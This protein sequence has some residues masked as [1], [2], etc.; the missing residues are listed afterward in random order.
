MAK[1]NIIKRI[2]WNPDQNRFRTLWR[3][4]IHTLLIAILTSLFTVGLLFLAVAF[5]VASGT[6]L[7]DMVAGT[8]PIELMNAPWV[9]LVIT[10]LAT[11]LGIFLATFLTGRWID[12]RP[13]KKFG[14]TFSKHWFIDLGFGLGL[15]ALLMGLIFLVGWLTGSFRVT[16]YFVVSSSNGGFVLALIQA[17]VFFV[18]V[19]I[20]EELLSR[21]YHLVNL[22]EG[23]NSKLIGERWALLFAFLVS[24]VVFGALHL[25]NPN[26]T[27]ISA[28]NITLAGLFLGLGMVLTGSLAIPIGLH[29][30]W[31]FFQGNVFGFAVSGMNI[32]ATII[33]TE[34]VGN[35]WL[36]G[37][38][39]GPESGLLSL[40]AMLIG[41]LLTVFWIRRSEKIR[42]QTDLAVYQPDETRSTTVNDASDDGVPALDKSPD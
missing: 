9:N 17:L 28:V 27:W 12:R 29:I 2:F 36:V 40:V 30:T 10:P 19:G 26:A 35:T 24:S 6:E 41:S 3:L 11:F 37:G 25:G 34:T 14:I 20:Y 15:G 31:N 38:A 16:G 22:A 32:G 13:F 42:L 4:G 1:P 33:A 5:D 23:F 18:F 21:G 7:Q 8:G 39:F